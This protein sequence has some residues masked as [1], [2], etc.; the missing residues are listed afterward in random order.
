MALHN[1]MTGTD[2]H[3]P[4]A[5]TYA[6]AV[7]REAASFTG[8]DVGKIAR[9]T[10]NESYWLLISD[11]IPAWQ[12]IGRGWTMVTFD[13]SADAAMRTIAAHTLGVILPINAYIIRAW[14]D[15]ITTFQSATDAAT[16]ELGIATDD[17]TGIVAAI[18]IS[19]VGTPWNAGAHDAIPDGAAANFTTKT[20]ARRLIQADVAV[21]ALTAGKLNL[22]VQYEQSA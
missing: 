19:D 10:D 14:Y 15:V 21:E 4:Y 13:P 1:A 17:A 16:I 2:V 5:F 11:T 18:A 8:A 3:I 20:T 22:F 6:S 12:Q 7:A 9:Q